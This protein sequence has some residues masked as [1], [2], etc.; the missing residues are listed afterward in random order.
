MGDLKNIFS[1]VFGINFI[2]VG[3][4]AFIVGIVSLV[5]RAHSV[6]KLTSIVYIIAGGASI[7]FGV[8]LSRSAYNM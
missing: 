8:V 7:Y 5:K 4:V 6:K 3:L 2:V 1:L